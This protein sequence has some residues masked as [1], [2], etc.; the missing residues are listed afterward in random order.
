ML[1]PNAWLLLL[2]K[3]A[4]NAGKAQELKGDGP[5]GKWGQSIHIL[6]YGHYK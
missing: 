6:S 2:Q 4:L 1:S 3:A 5:G